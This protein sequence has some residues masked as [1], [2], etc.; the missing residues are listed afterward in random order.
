MRFVEDFRER[1]VGSSMGWWRT[2]EMFTLCVIVN[3]ELSD[4]VIAFDGDP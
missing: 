3:L 4:I 2:F 1:L